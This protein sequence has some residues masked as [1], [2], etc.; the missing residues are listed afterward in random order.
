[1]IVNEPHRVAMMNGEV[2]TAIVAGPVR[3]DRVNADGRV[4]I[5]N[6]PSLVAF[7]KRPATF[8]T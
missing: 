5:V 8:A 4:V 7:V 1:M 6:G 2:L 3:V